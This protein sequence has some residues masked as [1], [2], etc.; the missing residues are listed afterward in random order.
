[1]INPY[2]NL[3]KFDYIKPP[4]LSEASKFL[5]DNA[6]NALPFLGGTDLFVQLRNKVKNV[7]YLVDTKQFEGMNEIKYN[8][9]KG[10]TIGAAVNMNR[11]IDSPFV[12]KHYPLLSEACSSV[13]SYQL[14]NRATIVGNICNASP[15]GDTIGACLLLG[16]VLEINGTEGKRMEPLYGFFLAPGNTRLKPGDIVTSIHF[17]DQIDELRG[18]YIKLGRNKLSDLAIVG[19]TAI[20]Y[21]D[22]NS[23]SGFHFKLALASVAPTPLIVDAVEHYLSS[24]GIS[25]Q[26]IET[27]GEIAMKFCTPIDDVRASARYRSAMVRN[28]V[29]IALQSISQELGILPTK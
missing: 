7:D 16:G 8:P 1:M 3:P 18:K 28:L 10:L 6:G 12:N 5:A 9:I 29:I 13:A 14:R 21:P 27:A 19:V 15:A 25:Q 4:S 2:P 20:G 26:S 11:V 24:V 17:P 22:D 23:P